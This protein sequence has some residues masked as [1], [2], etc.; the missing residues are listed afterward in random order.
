MYRFFEILPG[1]LVWSTFAFVLLL[2]WQLPL[3]AAL[4]IILFD[5]FWLLRAIYFFSLLYVTFREMRERMKIDWL[6]KLKELSNKY[7]DIYH[8]VILPM[9]KE[10]YALVLETFERLSAMNYP[11][12]K[13]IVVLGLEEA[14]GEEAMTTARMIK[15]KFEHEFF[16]LLVTKHP[17]CLPGEIPGK[18][19]NETWAARRAK[20]EIIDPAGIKYD[21]ILVS[22]F[23]IDTQIFPDYFGV[24]THTFLT[25]EKPQ[26]SS[27]QPVPLFTNNIFEAA[28]IGRLLAFSSTFWSMMQQTRPENL[29][30]FSSHSM[31]F[32]ALVE[33]GFWHT[34]IVSEDSRIFWQCYV[35]YRGDW[36]TEPLFYPVSMD[37]NV[38]PTFIKTML[39]IY[40]QQRRWAWGSENLAFIFTSFI[41]YRKEIKRKI[42]WTWT[43][44][45]SYHTWATSSFII[46]F[47]GWLPI[48]LGGDAFQNELISYNLPKTVGIIM[49]IANIGIATSAIF[50]V[51]LMP[52]KPAWFKPRHYAWYLLEWVLTPVLFIF[53][54]ALPAIEAQTRLMLGG[55][56]RLG[57]WVTPKSRKGVGEEHRLPRKGNSP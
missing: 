46:L 4:G 34:H 54:S 24:L 8:L 18:G 27:Y 11:K 13:F 10:P 36:R 21:C 1:A 23:D 29:V 14:G 43:S 17:S 38:A 12:N 5:I 6:Q 53:F 49:T 41:K 19:S 44:L 56:F 26:R 31:P 22:S 15:E 52:P 39:H 47:M 51:L 33:I 48:W 55:R 30:T 28:S 2:S 3:F 7:E 50:S 16:K 40:K 37:A 42:Y 9:H 35:H 25:C 32:K 20:E 45:E 57:F